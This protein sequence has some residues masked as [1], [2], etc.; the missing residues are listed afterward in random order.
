MTEA[1]PNITDIKDL[2]TGPKKPLWKKLAFLLIKIGVSGGLLY[3]F[4]LRKVPFTEASAAEP[5]QSIEAM[6]NNVIIPLFIFAGCFHL[7]GYVLTTFRWKVLLAG[8]GYRVR[9]FPLL[10]SWVSAGFFNAIMPSIIGGDVLLM[11]YSSRYIGD[12]YRTA[13]IIF[14]ARVTGITALVLICG[15]A[16]LFK[17][18][19]LMTQASELTLFWLF[20]VFFALGVICLMIAVQPRVATAIENL[21]DKIPVVKKFGGKFKMIF[22]TF[23]VYR[24]RKKHLF[25]AL[26]LSMLFQLNIV[27]Y[28]YVCTI[29]LGLEVPAVNVFI[30]AP[31][32]L[33]LMMLPIT[34]SGIG[35]RSWG[36][37]QLV[38][39]KAGQGIMME[40]IDVFWRTF[41]G[42]LGGLFLLI[43]KKRPEEAGGWVISKEEVDAPD[44]SAFAKGIPGE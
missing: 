28:Y 31:I 4:C 20:P 21:I 26:G 7:V 13:P 10:I 36:F 22:A 16:I 15:V 1:A 41:Y 18:S 25:A 44:L 19:T 17:I 9:Y 24:N 11:Y 43:R 14:I 27:F 2:Q 40:M 39:L 29:A 30:G 6:L 32:V 38:G 5:G 34:I 3:Y 12:G 37:Q 23:R 42:L 33:M 35:I 8:S